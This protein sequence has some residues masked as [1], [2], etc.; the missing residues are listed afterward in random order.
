MAKNESRSM[1]AEFA[2]GTVDET[3]IQLT[4]NR[5]GVVENP[6]YDRMTW[7][8]YGQAELHIDPPFT[9]AHM[10]RAALPQEHRTT[11]GRLGFGS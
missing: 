4:P 3:Y 1:G 5:G 9:E 6:P 11:R 7:P 2:Q 10:R 8:T